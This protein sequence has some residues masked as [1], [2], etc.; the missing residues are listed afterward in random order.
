[1]LHVI[2]SAY[3][4]NK[5]ES[6]TL[7]RISISFFLSLKTFLYPMSL[8][9]SEEP[10]AIV[11]STSNDVGNVNGK[12]SLRNNGESS[13]SHSLNL[14]GRI[15]RAFSAVCEICE[16]RRSEGVS[17]CCENLRDDCYA[18]AQPYPK[19][20][21]L[22]KKQ[23]I[24]TYPSN[25]RIRYAGRARVSLTVLLVVVVE[26]PDVVGRGDQAI[27]LRRFNILVI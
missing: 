25:K 20:K 8:A 3:L 16:S 12:P 23:Y 2:Y 1:M 13:S 15:M 26:E 17:V 4:I 24:Y 27:K 19:I 18:V 21:Y 5:Y 14:S 10:G 9:A 11:V 7:L 22:I 6:K